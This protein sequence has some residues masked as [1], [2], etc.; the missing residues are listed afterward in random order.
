MAFHSMSLASPRTVCQMVRSLGRIVL[1][2]VV[3]SRAALMAQEPK[4]PLDVGHRVRVTFPCEP[5]NQEP[6]GSEA[7]ACRA[8]GS[9]VRLVT[10]T[11]V[12][13]AGDST[14]ATTSAYDLNKVSR[15]EVATGKKS[16][17]LPGAAIGF[18]VGSAAAY[19]ALA[20]GGSTGICDQSANQDAISSGECVALSALV[21][22]VPGFGLGAV[23]GLFIRS[24]RW[25]DVPADQLRVGFGPGPGSA[26][27]LS[28]V[29]RH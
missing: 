25:R 23:V 15:V 2:I 9:M 6:A 11:I 3:A 14:S 18:V 16:H 21:G 20:S 4:P 17:W 29:I 7:R 12:L 10:D 26:L 8:E 19:A 5:A 27:E 22:G 1:I 28:I 13:A 24:E